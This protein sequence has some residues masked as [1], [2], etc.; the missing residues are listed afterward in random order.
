MDQE[1]SIYKSY[2]TIM[3]KAKLFLDILHVKKNMSP[4]LG[5]QKSSGLALYERAVR[6]PSREQKLIVSRGSMER[7]NKRIFLSFLTVSCTDLIHISQ[8]SY[9]HHRVQ[10]AK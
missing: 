1:K 3:E 4:H 7:D 9:L 6:S 10:R 2:R 5:S 8:I